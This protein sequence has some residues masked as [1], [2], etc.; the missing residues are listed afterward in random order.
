M[1]KDGHGQNEIDNLLAIVQDGLNEFRKYKYDWV[2]DRTVPQGW[3]T[4]IS[5]GVKKKTWVLSP[6]GHGSSFLVGAEEEAVPKKPLQF[7]TINSDF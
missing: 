3:K 6:D 7:S 2:E 1:Q 5:E 4:R